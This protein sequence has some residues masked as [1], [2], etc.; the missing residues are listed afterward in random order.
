MNL[1]WIIQRDFCTWRN[2]NS[3]IT[4]VTLRISPAQF[5][6]ICTWQRWMVNGLL[7]PTSHILHR[8]PLSPRPLIILSVHHSR[9]LPATTWDVTAVRWAP[10][11]QTTLLGLV[12]DN[13]AVSL[14][15]GP[16]RL[17]IRVCLVAVY[18]IPALRVQSLPLGTQTSMKS[19]GKLYCHS[20]LERLVNFSPS[21]YYKLHLWSTQ[22]Q[23][24]H[25]DK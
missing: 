9:P 6:T 4:T 12:D 8:P 25:N 24:S 11:Y 23:F 18:V 15:W 7:A 3:S 14:L 21:C 13:T 17:P 5:V 22:N 1:R 19:S 2:Y 16:N 10:H 20:S